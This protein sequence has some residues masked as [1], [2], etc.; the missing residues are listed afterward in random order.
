M[1][2]LCYINSGFQKTIYFD[3]YNYFFSLSKNDV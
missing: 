1:I 3:L 2:F